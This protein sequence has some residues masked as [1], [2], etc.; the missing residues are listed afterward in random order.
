MKIFVCEENPDRSLELII[1]NFENEGDPFFG[2]CY[3]TG[4]VKLKGSGFAA[5]TVHFHFDN[6]NIFRFYESLR[7]IYR[8]Q[9]GKAVFHSESKELNVT[10]H[11]HNSGEGIVQIQFKDLHSDDS[12]S[13]SLYIHLSTLPYIL[14]QLRHHLDIFKY[15][16]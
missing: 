4:K 14:E 2:G 7:K 11:I 3:F 10:V 5:E 13:S 9:E 8:E 1:T 15:C 6:H 16:S 12:F